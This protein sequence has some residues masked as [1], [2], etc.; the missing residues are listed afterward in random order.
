[1]RR[2]LIVT[3]DGQAEVV[4][5]TLGALPLISERYETTFFFDAPVPEDDSGESLLLEQVHSIEP[6]EATRSSER[7]M[8]FPQL[9]F[10]LL[11]PLATINPANRADPPRFPSGPFPF[12]DAF[13]QSCIAAGLGRSEIFR[14]YFLNGWAD[15]WP[16]LD[17]LL[18]R[19][20]MRL[21]AQ[22]AAFGSRIG[23]YV[24]E[25]FRERRLFLTPHSPTNLTLG[26]L[27][28]ELAER[29][30]PDARIDPEEI[31]Y[32]IASPYDAEALGSLEL[33]IHPAVA[34]HL[35]LTWVTPLTRYNY[36]DGE[37]LT[38]REYYVRFMEHVGAYVDGIGT[39]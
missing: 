16:N 22:D 20:T 12:G 37:I 2:S 32:A 5:R 1:M 18:N 39:G 29:L 26:A 25:H 14:L 19:E 4:A 30:V 36:F 21:Q 31:A 34:A 23:A 27:V 10:D 9:H 8:R 7:R 38:D 11:W 6:N 28:A 17:G 24:L 3:G 13:L 15:S 35:G 33:P